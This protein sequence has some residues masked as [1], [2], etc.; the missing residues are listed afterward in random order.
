MGLVF[1]CSTAVL[2]FNATALA[3]LII[4]TLTVPVTQSLGL[5]Y[6]EDI[7][8]GVFG[9][10]KVE[11]G[12][13][14][15]SKA[16][17]SYTVSSLTK[18]T[19]W[20]MDDSARDTLAKI[21]IV[22]PIAA[23]LTLISA[24]FNL[25]AHF[26]TFGSSLVF[27]LIGFFFTLLAFLGSALTC[28]VAILLFYP[29]VTWCTWL[30]IPAAVLNL[31]SVPLMF[32]AL[33]VTPYSFKQGDNDNESE[34]ELD[35]FNNNASG[36]N[37]DF[38]DLTELNDAA[39]FNNMNSTA[40]SIDKQPVSTLKIITNDSSSLSDTKEKLDLI[41]NY[42]KSTSSLN[43]GFGYYNQTQSS[44]LNPNS[45]PVTDTKPLNDGK[46]TLV[47]TDNH[48]KAGLVRSEVN[49]VLPQA[50]KPDYYSGVAT[51]LYPSSA[52]QPEQ[53]NSKTNS[54][55]SDESNDYDSDFTS[56]SQRGVNPRYYRNNS[57]AANTNGPAL[58]PQQQQQQPQQPQ[59]FNN[60][61]N[62]NNFTRSSNSSSLYPSQ[63]Q[64]Q[65]QPQ[66]QQPYYQQGPPPLSSARPVNQPPRQLASDMALNT[67]PDFMI[68]SGPASKGFAQRRNHLNPPSAGSYRPPYKRINQNNPQIPSAS[69]GSGSPYNFR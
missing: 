34:Q 29:H 40:N 15:C 33:R 67:N 22:T 23:G 3:F 43:N 13:S 4:A 50:A 21:L 36:K 14:T 63:P 12:V 45:N 42:S 54:N 44:N 27:Y 55:V 49:S 65:P 39:I 10:C 66:L 18:L 56:V 52:L 59:P 20:K 16:A 11:D 37:K 68:P 38:S 51:S 9:Y 35:H 46:P 7:R 61:N 31:V 25:F 6:V 5:A 62:G 28:V 58:L 47:S 1:G 64:A 32:F 2:V 57:G 69:L 41:N 48:N 53:H 30:L 17:A 26:E 19:D 8:Y 60:Y 24:L